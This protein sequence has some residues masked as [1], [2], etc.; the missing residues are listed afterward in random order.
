MFQQGK[1]LSLIILCLLSLSL[2]GCIS[3]VRVT[4]V[5]NVADEKWRISGVVVFQSDGVWHVTGSLKSASS[6]DL[7]NG[8]ILVSILADDGTL[9]AQQEVEYNMRIATV[10]WYRT[11]NPK[12]A[13]F[14]TTFASI[15][16]TA[17]VVTRHI[18]TDVD[19]EH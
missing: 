4:E 8:Y 19:S 5:V 1:A 15:P 3:P 16:E 17:K 2:V 14:A 11:R 9:L 6:D 12:V 7:P 13:Q 10:R 18:V